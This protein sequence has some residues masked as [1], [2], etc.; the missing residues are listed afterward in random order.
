M[1]APRLESYTQGVQQV[2][3]QM[4]QELVERA[5]HLSEYQLPLPLIGHEVGDG[6]YNSQRDYL[7]QMEVYK[8]FQGKIV[9]ADV[10]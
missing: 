10:R 4:R 7:E 1:L 3:D 5:V 6:L 8:A 9:E 2:W